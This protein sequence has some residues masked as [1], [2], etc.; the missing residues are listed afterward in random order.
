MVDAVIFDI[1]N[2]LIEWQPERHYDTLM[3]R[4]AREAM[5]AEVDLHGNERHHRPRRPV[6]RYDL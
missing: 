4:E 1:G 6:P 2:V 5:F 3:P